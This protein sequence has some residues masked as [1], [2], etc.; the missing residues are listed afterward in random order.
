MSLLGLGKRL[1]ALAFAFIIISFLAGAQTASAHTATLN[2]GSSVDSPTDPITVSVDINLDA[3]AGVKGIQWWF[4]SD[5]PTCAD[6]SPDYLNESGYH[7]HLAVTSTFTIPVPTTPGTHSF[8]YKVT[9]SDDCQTFVGSLQ[10]NGLTVTIP[11]PPPAPV[12]STGV[13][14]PLLVDVTQNI[15][16]DPDSSVPGPTWALDTFTRHIQIWQEGEGEGMTRSRTS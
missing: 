1:S 15:A 7:Q 5:A 11:E 3:G 4:D 13:G 2:G 9:N 6:I 12:C 8:Y 16:N 10:N 14:S